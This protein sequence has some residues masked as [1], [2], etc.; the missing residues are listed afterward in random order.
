MPEIKDVVDVKARKK[1]NVREGYHKEE[2]KRVQIYNED[3]IS[4][5]QNKI[6]NTVLNCPASDSDKA[7]AM[8]VKRYSITHLYDPDRSCKIELLFKLADYFNIP[9]LKFFPEKANDTVKVDS[10]NYNER[11]VFKTV[12]AV[13]KQ[14]KYNTNNDLANSTLIKYRRKDYEYL[15]KNL[16]VKILILLCM[17]NHCSVGELLRDGINVTQKGYDPQDKSTDGRNN[18]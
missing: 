11:E 2:K 18:E 3:D 17:T 10:A 4:W 9:F 15:K 6:K 16:S 12:E 14:T 1:R 13:I 8:G 5:I 7:K